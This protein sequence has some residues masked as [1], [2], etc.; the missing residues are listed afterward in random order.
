MGWQENHFQQCGEAAPFNIFLSERLP[1]S[2][3]VSLGPRTFRDMCFSWTVPE[4][5]PLVFII[6]PHGVDLVN[7]P[8]GCTHR[9]YFGNSLVSGLPGH[10]RAFDCVLLSFWLT[11]GH[12]LGK[13]IG[14][15]SEEPL[16]KH[17]GC[18]GRAWA[19][20]QIELS[21]NSNFATC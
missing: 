9:M 20:S 18:E 12:S 16:G 15:Q 4:C 13:A 2:F 5:W 10:T 21:L 8:P 6:F 7:M 1:D 3:H 19:W 11:L 17:C 14:A